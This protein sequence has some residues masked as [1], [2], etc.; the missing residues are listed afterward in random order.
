MII[1][2]VVFGRRF[3]SPSAS[4]RIRGGTEKSPIILIF[5]RACGA[6]PQTPPFFSAFGGVDFSKRA[7]IPSPHPPSF[8]PFC[9]SGFAR[10]FRQGLRR[11]FALQN[12]P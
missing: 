9:F 3:F 11:Y 12:A 2:I 8:L 10:F 6:V 4:W 5:N 7:K 1:L